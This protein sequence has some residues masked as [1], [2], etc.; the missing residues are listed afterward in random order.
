MNMIL[1]SQESIGVKFKG[2]IYTELCLNLWFENDWYFCK[3]TLDGFESD[4]PE[5]KS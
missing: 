3:F 1:S 5:T 2:N 4:C